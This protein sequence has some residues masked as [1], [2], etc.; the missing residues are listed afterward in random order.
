MEHSVTL[1]CGR[2]Y[3]AKAD[4]T[5]AMRLLD[6]AG[7]P[8][9]ALSYPSDGTALDAPH[10][11]ALLHE[12]PARVFKT[13]V[14]TGVDGQHFACLRRGQRPQPEGR[15]RALASKA[16]ACKS[17]FAQE[18]TGYV[19]GGCSPWYEEALPTA[20]GRSA[21]RQPYVLV[22]AGRIGQQIKLSPQALAR[23]TGEW[24]DLT[25]A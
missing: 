23:A 10:V 2:G 19:R 3:Y 1:K 16:C 25:Q 22:S 8:Y 7:I 12:D 5:N 4:K 15:R 17:R 21:L 20:A 11:A 6:R 9:E 24:A 13:L 18:L 14:L